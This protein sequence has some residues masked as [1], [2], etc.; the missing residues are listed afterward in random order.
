[1]NVRIQEFSMA[2][3]EALRA[4]FGSYFQPDDKLL[5]P[6]Y[7]SWLYVDNPFGTAQVAIVEDAGQWVGFMALVPIALVRSGGDRLLAYY[8]VNVLV[9]PAHHGKNLFGRMIEAAKPFVAARGAALIGHPNDMAIKSWVR[10]GMQFRQALLPQLVCPR[11]WSSGLRSQRMDG[12]TSLRALDAWLHQLSGQGPAWRVALSA[13]Y[14]QWR[15]FQHPTNRYRVQQVS[16]GGV[17]VAVLVTRQ[18][19]PGAHLLIDAF[20]AESDL[21]AACVGLPWLTIAFRPPAHAMRHPSAW[22]RLPIKK[23]MP[24]FLT[25]PGPAAPDADFA[26]LGLSSSDF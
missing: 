22:W 2:D 9:H 12:A 1:L 25:L 11:L 6:T 13:A 7:T 21:D 23:Q 10:N 18:I 16:R 4:L 26:L 5:S 19:R 24:M 17:P 3:F 15:F 14:L 8:V 20:A